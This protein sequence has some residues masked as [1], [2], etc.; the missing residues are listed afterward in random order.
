MGEVIAQL[1]AAPTPELITRPATGK[2]VWPTILLAGK[3][4]S[5]K[6]YAC[7]TAASYPMITETL[8][9]SVGEHDADALG[10]IGGPS[11]NLVHHDNTP[12]GVTTAITACGHHATNTTGTTLLVVDSIT[13]V[14]QMLCDA[15]Q[16]TANTR[17]AARG[18]NPDEAH[19][20][21][22][23][24]NVAKSAWRRMI[25]AIRAFPGP[26]L[27]TARMDEVTVMDGGGRPT[28]DKQWKIRAESDVA[29]EVDVVVQ[30]RSRTEV[31]IT[32]VRSLVMTDTTEA[33]AQP[34]SVGHL[35]AALGMSP[36]TMT[37]PAS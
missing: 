3:P 8:W 9:V 2:P 26:V 37:N 5:G 21:M 14:W 16:D 27:L 29:F 25:A 23:L 33:V 28:K 10:A 12:A 7:A 31:L 20:S 18:K 35:W 32:H 11:M 6:S 34:F 19:I 1:S 36:E 22:D 17:A 13:P 24:W 30:M 15:A 4:K